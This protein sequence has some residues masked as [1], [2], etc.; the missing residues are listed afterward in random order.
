MQVDWYAHHFF[1]RLIRPG[2]NAGQRGIWHSEYVGSLYTKSSHRFAIFTY[3]QSRLFDVRNSSCILRD[4]K[5]F[6]KRKGRILTVG[7][8]EMEIPASHLA[9]FVTDLVCCLE[10]DQSF[11][12][13][14]EGWQK[15]HHWFHLREVLHSPFWKT[16]GQSEA[17]IRCSSS[18]YDTD[19]CILLLQPDVYRENCS[20]P[21]V[22]VAS[23]EEKIARQKDDVQERNRSWLVNGNNLKLRSYPHGPNS[24]WQVLTGNRDLV[25]EEQILQF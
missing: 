11:P 8:L 20:S 13:C 16:L 5:T 25:R 12:Q 15:R 1:P 9:P 14:E 2:V 17:P 3:Q 4:D 24:Q 10:R 21:K 18:P 19:V 22:Q 23:E 7:W 6:Q